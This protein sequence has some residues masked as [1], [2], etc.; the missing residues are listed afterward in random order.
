MNKFQKDLARRVTVD[1]AIDQKT[2]EAVIRHQF[3]KAAKAM[4]DNNSV[5]ISGFGKFIFNTKKGREKLGRI[6]KAIEEHKKA[7]QG[8]ELSLRKRKAMEV[9][10]PILL[11][12]REQLMEKLGLKDED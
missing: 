3:N 10:L 2:V 5:E 11:T 8:D 1:T 9:K 7:L 6:N 12:Y 4:L